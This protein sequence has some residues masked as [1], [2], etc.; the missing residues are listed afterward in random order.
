M[1]FFSK[2]Q[3]PQ[4]AVIVSDDDVTVGEVCDG[5]KYEAKIATEFFRFFLASAAFTAVYLE[6]N[7]LAQTMVVL[8]YIVWHT[9]LA[10]RIIDPAM[11]AFAI[12]LG[13]MWFMTYNH[14][15]LHVFL[16]LFAANAIHCAG[17]HPLIRLFI[18]VPLN[19]PAVQTGL[20][21]TGTA[22][23]VYWLSPEEELG[24]QC[25]ASGFGFSMLFVT[26]ALMAETAVMHQRSSKRPFRVFAPWTD[27][28]LAIKALT[29]FRLETGMRLSSFA[30]LLDSE[31]SSEVVTCDILVDWLNEERGKSI[32][33]FLREWKRVRLGKN[34]S[35]HDDVE[36]AKIN[37]NRPLNDAPL[38]SPLLRG[39]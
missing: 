36:T 3:L 32:W 31:E 9:V 20:V 39:Y 18:H 33:N 13:C 30:Y 21:L 14:F 17:F 1:T 7:P 28:V 8:A 34:S 25:V 35:P 22:A 26:G 29:R 2:L 4:S 10:K 24:L 12:Y 6:I 19:S 27:V 11:W 5:I 16:Y 15:P 23:A 37:G 38:R